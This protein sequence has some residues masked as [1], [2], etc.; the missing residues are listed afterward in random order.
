YNVDTELARAEDLVADYGK[1]TLFNMRDSGV[2]GMIDLVGEIQKLLNALL[3]LAVIVAALGVVN[4]MVIN[5]SERGREIGLLRAVGATRRQ[6]RQSVIAEAVIFGAVSAIISTVFALA[7]LGLF[8]LIY[9]PNGAES[10]GLRSGWETLRLSFGPALRDLGLA[11][12]FSFV[13]GPIVA[14]L[15]AYYPA[16][17]AAAVNVVEATRSERISLTRAGD[18]RIE[19]YRR[20]RS[21]GL[22]LLLAMR[23]ISRHRLRAE[24]SAFAVSLGV[25]MTITAEYVSSA[26]LATLTNAGAGDMRIT[27]GFIVEQFDITIG[28]VGYVLM[29]AAAFL[30][31]NAFA[32]SITERQQQIGALRSLGMTRRQILRQV[33]LEAFIIGGLGTLAGLIIGP[34]MGQGIVSIMQRFGGE[35]LAFGDGSVSWGTAVLASAIG[36][37]VT[38]LSA[39]IPA[40]RATRVSPLAAMRQTSDQQP[41]INNQQPIINRQSLIA[42]LLIAALFIYLAIAPPGEW[43]KTPWSEALAIGLVLVWLVCL[44]LL[45]PTLIRFTGTA[46]RRLIGTKSASGRLIGDNIQRSRGRVVLTILT[47]A[48]GLGTITGLTG[49]MTYAFDDL[50]GA[51]IRRIAD[52]NTWAVF[53]FDLESGIAGLAELNDIALPPEAITAVQTA[54]SDRASIVPVRFSVVPELS[55]FGDSYFTYV[56]DPEVVRANPYFFHFNEGDW[57]T[58]MPIMQSGCGA[59]VAPLIANRQGVGIGDTLTITGQN[60]PMDCTIAGIGAGYVNASIVGDN[61]G[62]E[63]GATQPIGLSIT[64]EPG[65]DTAVLETDLQQTI[66]AIPGVYLTRMSD[67]AE[68]QDTALSL[69]VVAL[70]GMLLLAVIAA[71]LGILNTT[72][73]SI[74]ERRQ[75]LGLLRAVG[76]TRRQIRQ[77]VMG[78][79]ALIGLVGA[80]FGVVAGMGSVVI[81]VTTL[82]G[83]SWGVT[84][85]DLWPAAGRALRP[86]ISNGIVGILA[87]P[88]ISAWVAR[89]PI[90]SL[91]RG[92]AIATLNPEQQPQMGERQSRREPARHLYSLAWRNLQE[93]RL[94]AIFS[95][96]AVALGVAMV[97]AAKVTSSGILDSLD[98]GAGLLTFFI[99]TMD[100]IFLVIGLV[101]LGAAGFLIFNAFAMTV[102]QRRQQI[103]ILRSLGMTR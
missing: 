45:L 11:A 74:H 3:M 68:T 31:F 34:L 5:V 20:R 36:L 22:S 61:V 13:F 44:G 42:T 33:L 43:I 21:Q 12:L 103:G 6:V 52:Q 101:I 41:A 76:A 88:L 25:A 26:L 17:Q 32:M 87:A 83:S 19:S 65:V 67:F 63:L 94:R 56:A 49:F 89:W 75:E 23:N 39:L 71:A 28:M 46:S 24:F 100:V 57:E 55:F 86:T 9:A 64:P 72:V 102:A 30:I 80:I 10:V 47:L 8:A 81:I 78:E 48:V 62:D 66:D 85:L 59:L 90:R 29:G 79:N 99:E 77:V 60:G 18:G 73:M 96:I 82:G 15:A 69:F 38:I 53:P 27:H 58:A 35:F 95:A 40:R 2:G 84:D 14:S 92:S 97:I 4:T 1:L 16:R 70:N 51:S 7:E 93:Q 37:G 91:L 50:M 98:N 54:A